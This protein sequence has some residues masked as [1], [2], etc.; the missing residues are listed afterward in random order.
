M[1]HGFIIDG[2]TVP[3]PFEVQTWLEN[4]RLAIGRDDYYPR[5]LPTITLEVLHTITGKGP[6]KRLPGRAAKS[7]RA[8]NIVRDWRTRRDSDG[9]LVHAGAQLILTRDT[10]F[11]QT[12]DLYRAAAYHAGCRTNGGVNER[13]V[14]IECEISGDGEMNSDQLDTLGRW[15]DWSTSLNN[16]RV[17]VPRQYLAGPWPVPDVARR[18]RGIIGHRDVGNRGEYDPGPLVYEVLAALGYERVDLSTGQAEY[19]ARWKA[20]QEELNAE[21]RKLGEPLLTVDGDPGP[22]TMRAARRFL[23]DGQWVQRPRPV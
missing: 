16:D 6:Q 7:K 15:F 5:P 12:C 23:P 17:A 11:A 8:E 3:G 9:E 14:G 18:F 13:S 19:T 20:R 21:L 4:D 10:C 2:A 1:T 22:Q